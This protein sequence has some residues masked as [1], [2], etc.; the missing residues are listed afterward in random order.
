[1]LIGITGAGALLGRLQVAQ[2]AE[3][4]QHMHPRAVRRALEDLD[5]APLDRNGLDEFR[6]IGAKGEVLLGMQPAGGSQRRVG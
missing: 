6:D 5:I 4:L 3:D 1:M 2:D